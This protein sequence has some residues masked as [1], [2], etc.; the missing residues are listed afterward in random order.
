MDTTTGDHNGYMD[1]RRDRRLPQPADMI[2][3]TIAIMFGI[4]LIGIG[5]WGLME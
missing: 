2:R 3:A 1:T 5:M 4:V